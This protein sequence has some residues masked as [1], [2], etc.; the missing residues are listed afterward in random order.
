MQFVGVLWLAAFGEMRTHQ[1]VDK[2]K[3]QNLVKLHM[4][5]ETSDRLFLVMHYAK[6]GDLL[7]A[8]MGNEK[9]RLSAPVAKQW[10]AQ[11]LLGVDYL[12]QH[13]V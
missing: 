7:D 5:V 2:L 1:G 11:L 10:F 9:R 4:H 6:G 12:H 8:V 13:K 3:H